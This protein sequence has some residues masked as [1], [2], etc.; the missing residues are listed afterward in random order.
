MLQTGEVYHDLQRF[1]GQRCTEHK[2]L[3]PLRARRART[4]QG[5]RSP[6]CRRVT[7]AEAKSSSGGNLQGLEG[8]VVSE[9]F[10]LSDEAFG[11]AVGVLAGVVVAAEYR[12]FCFRETERFTVM[13]PDGVSVEAVAMQRS[14][15]ALTL[16]DTDSRPRGSA[17]A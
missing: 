15:E 3:E 9:R 12:S 17:L 1:T 14:V 16:S 5:L 2:L 11:D 6:A 4:S 8:D 10:E 7:F 13:M